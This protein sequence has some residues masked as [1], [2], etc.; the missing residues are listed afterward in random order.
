LPPDVVSGLAA[1]SG[2]TQVTLVR[3]NPGEPGQWQYGE[4]PGLLSCADL[5][6]IPQHGQCLPGTAV[7]VVEPDLSPYD[8]HDPSAYIWPGATATPEEIATLPVIGV[9]VDTDGSTAALEQTRTVLENGFP[10]DNLTP[11]SGRDIATESKRTLAGW[12]QLANVVIL[13]SLPIAGCSLAVSIAGGLSQRKRPFSLLR[14]TGVPLK[15]LRNVV[16]LESAAPLLASAV[17]AIGTGLVACDLFLRSQM[18]YE[19]RPLGLGYYVIVAVGIAASLGII[20]STLP[21]LRRMTGPET[22]RNE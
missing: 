19:L 22:A 4:R 2:I 7:A 16:A 9:V 11:T 10:S 20:A 1:I 6:K 12:Q 14:L 3:T 8:V 5:A 18:H 13:T 15:S 21:L 17:V